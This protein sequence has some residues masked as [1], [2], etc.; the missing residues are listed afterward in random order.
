M[1]S[2]AIQLEAE[3]RTP[4]GGSEVRKACPR[5]GWRPPW[6]WTGRVSWVELMEARQ[7]PDEGHREL[8]DDN[9]QPI[10]NS[11]HFAFSRIVKGVDLTPGLAPAETTT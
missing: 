10:K 2:A 9:G 11:V 8:A 1:R 3:R 5:F 7:E 4:G 6:T